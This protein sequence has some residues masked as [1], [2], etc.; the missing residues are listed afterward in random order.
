MGEELKM[1]QGS[2]I[3]EVQLRLHYQKKLADI[4]KRIQE[5]CS[6]YKLVKNI[7]MISN[8]FETDFLSVGVSDN[9]STVDNV[10]RRQE[11]NV[12]TFSSRLKSFFGK[13]ILPQ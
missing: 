7:L 4:V 10:T 2:Y 5:R 9:L 12:D 8:Q 13:L 11:N 1:K 3:A 6:D